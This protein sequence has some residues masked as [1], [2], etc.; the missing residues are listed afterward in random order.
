M[1][2]SF[3]TLQLTLQ[4]LEARY[5]P[6]VETDRYRPDLFPTS[7]VFRSEDAEFNV[8]L[9]DGAALHATVAFKTAPTPL[10]APDLL[11]RFTG[12]PGWVQQPT[13]DARFAEHFPMFSI[14]DPRNAFFVSA[15]ASMFALVQRDVAGQE[16]ML[17][18]SMKDYISQ[19][20]AYRE[21]Q[22]NG[23]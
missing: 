9:I 11:Q 23:A 10:V 17:T 7:Y 13:T 5:G 21:K 18:L 4:E 12:P 3:A 2:C 16:L 14:T 15:D 22:R 19:L 20:K 8:T 1:H 6:V